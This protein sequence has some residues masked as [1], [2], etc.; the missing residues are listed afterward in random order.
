MYITSLLTIILIHYLLENIKP[1][2]NISNGLV[3][4]PIQYCTCVYLIFF[5]NVT[6]VQCRITIYNFFV[7]TI[8][9][10]SIIMFEL[11]LLICL[12]WLTSSTLNITVA[13]NSCLLSSLYLMGTL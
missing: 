13:V 9:L 7:V 10:S 6:V 8:I 3:Y 12:Q 11:C 4:N 5:I 1:V 2:S